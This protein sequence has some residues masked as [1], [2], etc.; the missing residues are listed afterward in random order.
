MTQAIALEILNRIEGNV[1]LTGAPGSGK[2]YILNTYISES[3]KHG[4]KVAVTASTGIAASLLGGTTL[5][6][7]AGLGVQP[8]VGGG[9]ESDP[10]LWLASRINQT[11]ILI[12]DEISMLDGG[13]LDRLELLLRRV[14]D[15][16]RP[17]GGLKIVLAGDF[18]QLPPVGRGGYAFLSRSWNQLALRVCYITE[19]YRQ[20]GDELLQILSALRERRFSS[21]HLKLLLERRTDLPTGLTRLM[22]HN[23][24]VDRINL[25]ELDKL[26]RP[27]RIFEMQLSGDPSVAQKL[28]KSV[29]APSRLTLKV[30]APVMFVANNFAA[31]YVNGSQGVIVRFKR[32]LPLVKLKDGPLVLAN[33]HEWS[34][35]S[36]DLKQP[37]AKIIQLPLRL[38]W[39]MTIHKSQGMSLDSAEVNLDR[40]FTYGMG[41]VALSRLKSYRG[42]YLS[43]LNSRSLELDPIIY[44]LDQK[45]RR[46]S[47]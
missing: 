34:F 38:A 26:R 43:G 19:Q 23:V 13:T 42:L 28:A 40:S 46:E 12:I 3:I 37:R 5:H 10:P 29:L 33:A 31:G 45:L 41:Y 35:A 24:A 27:S 25:T 4:K 39:A 7:W 44:D 6:S 18:F 20:Q 36:A 8:L 11:D 22:T 47:A 32:G 9:P 21:L 2:S 16:K 14:R 15:P 30:G 1:F 17:F